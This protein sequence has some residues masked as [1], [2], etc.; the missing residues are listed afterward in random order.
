[1]YIFFGFWVQGIDSH[2]GTLH[3]LQICMADILVEVCW[4][5]RDAIMG[6]ISNQRSKGEWDLG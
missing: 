6:N 5:H 2:I 4:M 1:M 3:I